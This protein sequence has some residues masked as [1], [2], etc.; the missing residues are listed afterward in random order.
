MR[1][2]KKTI[3]EGRIVTFLIGVTALNLEADSVA[4]EIKTLKSSPSYPDVT[5]KQRI[6]R[7][8]KRNIAG[9][10]ALV[11]VRAYLPDVVIAEASCEMEDLLADFILDFKA[12]LIGECRKILAEYQCRTDFDE[13]Y[14]VYCVSNYSG[15]PEVF[16]SL[17][18]EKIAALLKNER[19]SLDE[20]EIRSTLYTGHKYAKDD[21][22]LVDWDGAFV[23]EPQGDFDSNIELFEIA[24]LQLLKLRILDYHLDERLEKSVE[25]LKKREQKLFFRSREVRITIKE[26]VQIRT[27]T[28]LESEAIEHNI[29]LI[30]DW[31][32]ARLYNLL[33]KKFHLDDWRKN[34]NEKIDTLEDVYTIAS[35]NFTISIGTTLEFIIIGGWFFLLIGYLAL[36]YMEMAAK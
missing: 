9:K 19:I 32:S 7:E 27:Q 4:A 16:L 10:E 15:D 8:E 6:I 33:S 21:M 28:I 30:G 3:L 18:G 34:V 12:E 36:F 13:D 20:D 29:K 24:N 11:T 23:F 1:I 2:S 14:I 31:Y 22:T 5:P 26:I 35:E 25:L 17:H